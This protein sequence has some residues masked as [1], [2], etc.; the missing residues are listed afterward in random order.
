MS[1]VEQAY[2]EQLKAFSDEFIR[3][4][5]PLQILD[6]IKWPREQEAK[7]LASG[8]TRMPDIDADFYQRRAPKYDPDST[9]EDLKALK[10]AI[11]KRLGAKDPLGRILVKNIEQSQLLIELLLARGTQDFGFISQQLYGSARHKL[12]GDRHTLR[13][14]GDRLSYL[15]SLPAARRINRQ[16]PKVV[17]AEDAVDELSRRLN[18]YFHND[19]ILVRLSDGIVSDA[20]VGGD[21]I[22]LNSQAMFSEADLNV[23]EVHEGWVHL[24]TTLNGR[25]QPWATW[26]RSGTPRVAA[27]QEGLAVLLEMLTLSSTPGRARRISDRVAAVDMAENGADFI[28]VYRH[29]R[30]QNLSEKDSY[31]VT[32]RVFRGGVV[33]GGSCFT[34]DISYVRGYVENINFIRAAITAGMPEL[35]PMLFVGKLAIEDIPVLYQAH[36]Q[37]IVEAP[38][39]LPYMFDDYSG[40]YAWFGFA[41]GLAGIDLKGVQRHFQRL[42]RDLPTVDPISEFVDDTEFDDNSD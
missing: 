26:L 21:T 40:L 5:S 31:R 16:H 39:Y 35:I 32:Q 34:K 1:Q 14:L 25:A 42:F 36:K 20:A 19:D 27:T 15:F 8:G 22:K 4:Q 12:H 28:E 7:F 10:K 30:E 33:T 3:L 6:A 11:R 17:S 38:E 18:R 29:F 9:R 24:G 13:Q 37:G 41:T 23:Y 2:K